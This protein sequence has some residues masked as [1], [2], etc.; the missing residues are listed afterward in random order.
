MTVSVYLLFMVSLMDENILGHSHKTGSS[1]YLPKVLLKISNEHCRPFLY[2]NLPQE[3]VFQF[4]AGQSEWWKNLCKN[5]LEQ[6]GMLSE[7]HCLATT[8]YGYKINTEQQ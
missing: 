4:L 7:H 5:S 6:R 1:W 2:G 3:T 8:T